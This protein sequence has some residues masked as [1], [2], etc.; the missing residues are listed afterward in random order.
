MGIGRGNKGFSC[1]RCEII[2]GNTSKKATHTVVQNGVDIPLCKEHYEEYILLEE[3]CLDLI[4][5]NYG[6]YDTES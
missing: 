2:G 1:V 4:E 3:F 6:D 5:E